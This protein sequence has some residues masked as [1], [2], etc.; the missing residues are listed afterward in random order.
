MSDMI[1]IAISG[2][3]A[4]QAALN[5][6]GN[7]ITNASTPGYT[8]ETA[9]ITNAQPQQEGAYSQGSGATVVGVVRQ[10]SSFLNNQLL[11]DT[12]QS[13]QLSALSTALSRINNYV[14]SSSTGLSAQLQTMFNDLQ[15]A[16]S[17]PS[18]LA[19]RQVVVSDLQTLVQGF[20]ASAQEIQSENQSVN[21]AVVSDVSQINSLAKNIATLNEQL[22]GTGSLPN[23]QQPNAL[24][25]NR[26]AL[27]QQLSQL[28]SVSV[29]KDGSG[30]DNIFIGN[31]QALVS[32]VHASTLATQAAASNSQ[33]LDVTLQGAQGGAQVITQSLS[34]G[35]L[36][37]QLSYQNN[38]LGAIQN[39]IGQLALVLANT[40]NQQNQLGVDLNGQPGGKIFADINT[41]SAMASRITADARNPSP[42]TYAMGVS[43]TSTAQLTAS[44][45]TLSFSP[46]G[47]TYSLT[48]ASDGQV[49]AQGQL[50]ATL[51]ATINADGL[52]INLQSGNYAA[53][54]TFYISPTRQAASQ[55]A[56]SLTTPGQLAFAWPVNASAS[57]T[58]QGSGSI[59]VA[60][61]NSV[62][63]PAFTTTPGSMTPPVL[64]KFTSAT[65][66]DVLNNS[67]PANPV[68][69]SPPLVNQPYT[70]GSSNTLFSTTSGEF[71]VSSTGPAAGVAVA[72]S[73][74]G[75]P[76]E[77]LSLNVYNS[78]TN[79]VTTTAVSTTAGESA[80]Q[81]AAALNTVNGVQAVADTRAQISAISSNASFALS[82]NGQTLTGSTPD[83]LATSINGNGI[84]QQAGIVAT[85]NGTTL[86]VRS[87]QGGDLSFT[88]AG[89][90]G[91]ALQV[92]GSS[93]AAQSLNSSGS[94]TV[95]GVVNLQMPGSSSVTTTGA[96]LFTTSPA[97]ASVY[98]GYTLSLSGVPS[99]GDTFTV[100]YN[101]QSS[102]DARNGQAMLALQGA[103][104]ADQGQM[105]MDGLYGAM[106]QSVGTQTAQAQNSQSAASTVLQNT[107][108]LVTQVSG[109]NLNEEAVNLIQFQQAYSASAQVINT[110]RT[111]FNS[112]LTAVGA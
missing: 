106:V 16:L 50:P 62:S 48:R 8:R 4:A 60:S 34:G 100:A 31:G 5:T 81:I 19:S 66:Y 17:N 111:L 40:M 105:T 98:Q 88:L 3:N 92:T 42:Q 23:G 47:S 43:I 36:G 45:Y 72:G 90:A 22:A 21:S 71:Q 55:L 27:L 107:T 25:D 112:L 103:T 110:A 94:A 7:N 61:M 86:S 63:T 67:N 102:G 52:A 58:N 6:I 69:W 76:A 37:G 77:T 1:N 18:S 9:I 51:P 41:T 80:Q 70:P 53:G 30:M 28:V 32:G 13:S 54:S 82:L 38:S 20:N 64:I 89:G 74:N 104:L 29:V 56:M 95:G 79:A 109:V 11:T 15:S 87:L 24:L 83:A 2:I 108:Q 99:T 65:T 46:P 75:Y 91:N 44:N 57:T 49:V 26:D 59:S 10:A 35:S 39:S 73:S 97:P 68:A 96:G 33:N 85:S 78:K 12:A 101:T 93:G 84:L 14:A